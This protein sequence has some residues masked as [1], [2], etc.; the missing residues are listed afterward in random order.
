MLKINAVLIGLKISSET[1]ASEFRSPVP[2]FRH[3]FHDY[4]QH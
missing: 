1:D 4:F 3:G 2:S